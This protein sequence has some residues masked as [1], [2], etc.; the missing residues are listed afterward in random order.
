MPYITR[1]VKTTK[2]PFQT[3]PEKLRTERII[4]FTEDI[5]QDAV[6]S[7]LIH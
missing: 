6:S 4:P 1:K 3:E 7:E 2:L 5:F